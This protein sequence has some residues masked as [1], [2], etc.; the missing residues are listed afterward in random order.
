[1]RIHQEGEFACRVREEPKLTDYNSTICTSIHCFLAC[2]QAQREQAQLWVVRASGEQQSDPAERGLKKRQDCLVSRLRCCAVRACVPTWVWLQ[3]NCFLTK[4][5][6][7]QVLKCRSF[8]CRFV[9]YGK[10]SNVHCTIAEKCEIWS[11]SPE[12]LIFYTALRIRRLHPNFSFS[13][14][15]TDS[16]IS[17]V[18]EPWHFLSTFVLTGFFLDLNM[19]WNT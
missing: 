4:K 1:M 7:E 8:L 14:Q 16:E 6:G 5:L 11:F 10:S 12:K 3:T 2:E 9:C 15:K 13:L 18:C 19:L 17:R